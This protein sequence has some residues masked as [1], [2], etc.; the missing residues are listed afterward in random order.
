[1][2]FATNDDTNLTKSSLLWQK[3]LFKVLVVLMVKFVL[4]MVN[5]FMRVELR[6]A[7]IRYGELSVAQNQ[8]ISGQHINGLVK[9]PMSC[10][11]NSNTWDL[12]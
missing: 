5:Q 7:S 4:L 9:T 11:D 8:Q 1:M 6:Y 2:Q 12:V 10:V 3:K